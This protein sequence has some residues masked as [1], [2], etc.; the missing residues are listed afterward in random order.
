[1]AK[2][3]PKERFISLAHLMDEELL[4]RA[5]QRTRKDGAVGVD[6][7]TAKAYAAN[8]KEN[9][10]D[11]HEKL[12]SGRYQP[13][14]VRRAYIEKDDGRQR[15]LGIPT[16]EDK[17]AQRAAATLLE[18]VYEQDFLPCSHGF[19][20]K[21]S[22]HQALQQLQDTIVMKRVRW[23]LE[24]DIE[25]FFG[26][27]SHEW[28][29]RMLRHRIKDGALNRL[30]GRWLRAGV[31]EEG[32]VK[33]SDLGTPQG[34]VISPILA[35]LYLHH[36]IDLW[37][38]KGIKKT[39]REEAYLFRYADDA[40]FC[41]ESRKDA[42]EVLELL[43]ERLSKFSLKL[44]ADKTRL[45]RFGRWAEEDG[46]GR[47]ETFHFL[48]FTHH[49]G[50]TRTG[51]FTVKRRTMVKRLGRAKKRVTEWC[52][53]NRH[54]KVDEQRAGLNEILRGHYGYYGITG[55][56]RC[57]EHFYGHVKRTWRSWLDRRG[58]RGSMPWD[59]YNEVLRRLPLVR[60]TIV[61][62]VYAT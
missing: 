43:R 39:L 40:V 42:E 15:P 38:E 3:R 28:S 45:I 24:I 57:L 12:R 53:R 59:R 16:V 48:G 58:R 60:P 33:R 19:R 55:N 46:G 23:V 32:A 31:M 21:R 29:L 62:S 6:G 7:Q 22:A 8:L 27:M 51:K 41:F 10:R 25:D 54:L 49:V 11:L 44:H 5:W 50:R 20:P 35:N 17:V 18:T 13:P 30:V 26:T 47:P 9:L 4:L 37:F 14:P 61:H 2:E 56:F 34:G 52:R 1:M 36:V